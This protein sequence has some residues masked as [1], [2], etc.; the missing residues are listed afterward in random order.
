MTWPWSRK[1]HR[2]EVQEGDLKVAVEAPSKAQA[3]VLLHETM[4]HLRQ[5]ISGDFR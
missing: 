2:I 3:L 5:Q 1:T 4:Q